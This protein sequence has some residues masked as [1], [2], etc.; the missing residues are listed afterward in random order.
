MAN[1][2]A[3]VGSLSDSVQVVSLASTVP[4]DAMRARLYQTLKAHWQEG[5]GALSG[6]AEF[7]EQGVKDPGY[8]AV[9]KSLNRQEAPVKRTST[10]RNDRSER[11]AEEEAPKPEYEWMTASREAV[12]DMCKR[13]HTAALNES[14]K[15]SEV[16]GSLPFELHPEAQ[17]TAIYRADW[18][19][20]VG[21]KV[22]GARLDPMRIHYVRIEETGKFGTR[23][24]FYKRE[25]KS[26]EI[27]QLEG[28]AWLDGFRE[29]PR[30]RP[31]AVD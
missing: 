24:A 27:R 15:F 14:D 10:R 6:A 3:G 21:K 9:I 7:P 2:L 19:D 12:Q 18:L 26:P 17:P 16:A 1:Q 4:N 13:F 30:V 23:L 8:L 11:T 20:R 29:S 28:G 22:A 25:F 5:P 31:E